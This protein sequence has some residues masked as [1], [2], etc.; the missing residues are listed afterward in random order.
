MSNLSIQ[1]IMRSNEDFGKR[2]VI[3]GD[4]IAVVSAFTKGRSSSRALKA[5][6]QR[7]AAYELAEIFHLYH[8]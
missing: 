5:P 2:V 7:A 8:F 6:C 3:L 1:W 4:K